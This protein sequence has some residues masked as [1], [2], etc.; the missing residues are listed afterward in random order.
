VT[1]EYRITPRYPFE[2]FVPWF[3]VGSCLG[4]E[5]GFSAIGIAV[6]DRL[7]IE[8]PGT[9]VTL[10]QAGR[11]GSRPIIAPTTLEIAATGADDAESA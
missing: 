8:A 3:Q 5:T 11:R 9:P 2:P 4:S 1:I 10:Q 6:I 7:M